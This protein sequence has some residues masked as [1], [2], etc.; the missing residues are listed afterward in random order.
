MGLYDAVYRIVDILGVTNAIKNKDTTILI[1]VDNT[2]A[3]PYLQRP[4]D[5]GVDIIV[6]SITKLL[7][8]HSDVTLGYFSTNHSE[9]F[10][11]IYQRDKCLQLC[12]LASYVFSFWLS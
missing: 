8:G 7:S 5:L 2:F 9:I 10:K 11:K 6:H 1:A 4:L 3:T 12:V